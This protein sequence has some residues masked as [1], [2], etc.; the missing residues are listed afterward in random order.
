[1][2]WPSSPYSVNNAMMS[3]YGTGG[4]L[5]WG[6]PVGPKNPMLAADSAGGQPANAAA[7]VDGPGEPM[8]QLAG[9]SKGGCLPCIGRETGLIPQSRLEEIKK[10]AFDKIMAHEMAHASEAGAFG[11]GIHIEYDEN[12]IAVGGHVPIIVPG[13]DPENP[14]ESLRAYLQ[15][16]DAA[17]APG[18]DMSSQDAAVASLAASNLGRAQVAMQNKQERQRL[19]GELPGLQA[20]ADLPLPAFGGSSA[21]TA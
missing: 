17:L 10:E 20:M 19:L 7:G 21:T 16:Q 11:G 6:S 9:A 4:M 12:G 8:V 2:S 5:G 18:S 1:M 15:I 14:E 13:L 3:G